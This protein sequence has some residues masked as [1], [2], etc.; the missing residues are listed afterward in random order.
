MYTASIASRAAGQILITGPNGYRNY[1]STDRNPVFAVIQGDEV[2][3]TLENGW[4]NIHDFRTSR[5]IRTIT[6]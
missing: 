5:R 4:I 2:H 6:G 3:V 1:V